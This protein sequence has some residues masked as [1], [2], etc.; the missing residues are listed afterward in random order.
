MSPAAQ[1]RFER[2]AR[3][4]A[5]KL[6][7]AQTT[8]VINITTVFQIIVGYNNAG[9]VSSAM[10]QAQ[11]NVLNAAFAPDFFFNLAR[12]VRTYMPSAYNMVNNAASESSAKA[13]RLGKQRTLNIY[14]AL[15]SG[16]A[17]GWA[18]F[19]PSACKGSACAR[20]CVCVWQFRCCAVAWCL[21]LRWL[22]ACCS[23]HSSRTRAA[24]PAP[25]HPCCRLS[26]LPTPQTS[27]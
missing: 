26:P 16:G 23:L 13:L 17:L 8:G 18:T 19:P 12:V 20:A 2:A 15:L 3:R 4:A 14:T 24:A 22:P 6:T 21:L 5:Q 9:N 25:A 27:R 7:P 11:M 1:E 10:I